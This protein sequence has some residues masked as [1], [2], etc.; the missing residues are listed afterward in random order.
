MS[1]G[2]VA[3]RSSSSRASDRDWTQMYLLNQATGQKTHR[4]QQP[5]PLE[6]Q[7]MLIWRR[8]RQ[9]W[10][11]IRKCSSKRR[12]TW[13][14]RSPSNPPRRETTNN[15]IASKGR[16]EAHRHL[17]QFAGKIERLSHQE[18]RNLTTTHQVQQDSQNNLVQ[19]PLNQKQAQRD[20]QR[21]NFYAENC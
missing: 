2:K 17:L 3:I 18:D 5:S 10:I 16:L 21:M 4:S 12:K 9:K 14:E 20:Y 8:Y 13:Q 15:I 19:H 11:S 7:L 6:G 1:R